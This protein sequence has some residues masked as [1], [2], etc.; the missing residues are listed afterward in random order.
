MI[1]G[2]HVKMSKASLSLSI[3]LSDRWGTREE[4]SKSMSKASLSISFSD[5][6]HRIAE[7]EK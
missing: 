5:I 1:D 6:W 4:E 3:S 7:I 2:G